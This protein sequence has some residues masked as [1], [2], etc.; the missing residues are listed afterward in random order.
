MTYNKLKNTSIY[1][2]ILTRN[3]TDDLVNKRKTFMLLT[4]IKFN[5]KL[6]KIMDISLK[7]QNFTLSLPK[8]PKD[9]TEGGTV[10]EIDDKKKN[11][12]LVKNYIC[13]ILFNFKDLSEDIF[14]SN[15][16][17]STEEIFNFPSNRLLFV[18]VFNS[19]GLVWDESFISS[20]RNTTRIYR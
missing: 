17:K 13:K 4:S 3:K 14:L 7:N 10:V 2:D 15:S 18:T 11:L 20:S 16:I 6:K 8:P 19:F 9:D 12:I 5:N 1:M